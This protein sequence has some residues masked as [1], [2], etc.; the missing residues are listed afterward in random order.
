MS[1][2][3]FVPKGGETLGRTAGGSQ[4][5]ERSRYLT[6]LQ[7]SLAAVKAGGGG[8][9]VLIGGEA[10]V[11]KTTLIRHFC[12]DQQHSARILWGAC[13][14]LFTP[15]ALGPFLAIAETAGGELG[16]L[17]ASEARPHEVV[18]ALFGELAAQKPT[19]LV[20]ED[21]HWAD[22][23]TLDVL[24]LL[25]RRIANAPALVLVT[26]RDDVLGRAH[27][28]RLLLGELPTGDGIER[29]KL[30]PLSPAAVAEL[31]QPHGFNVDELYRLTAGNPF[32][33]TEAL[34]AGRQEIPVTV[35]DAVLARAAR[36]SRGGSVV[37]EAVAVVPGQA[38]LWL[39]EAVGEDIAFLDECVAAGMLVVV[40]GGVT[41]RHEL[42]RLAVEA[43]LAP[44]RRAWLHRAMLTAL[45]APASGA[46]DLARLAHHAEAAH[47]PEAVLR[48]APVAALRAAALGA[49]REA[50]AQYARALRFANAAPPQTLVRLL[51]GRAQE[52]YLT[53]QF[54][55]AIE[56]EERALEVH[57]SAGNLRQVG[58]ALRRL[59]RLRFYVGE[60]PQA[61]QS[62]REAVGL[63]EELPPG[64]ELAW[65]YSTL[66]MFEEDADAI[67]AWG[68]RAIELGQR[69]DEPEILCHALTNVG[70]HELLNGLA[71]GREK[72][73]RSL[74]LAL[75]E[76][77]EEAA[78][79]A[80]S[81][82]AIAAVRT[83]SYDLAERV[84]E[85]GIEYATERD[86]SN[87]RLIQLAQRARLELDRGQWTRA[88]TSAQ[89]ALREDTRPYRVFALPVVGLVRARR[90]ETGVW[91]ALDEASALAPA[92]E[93]LRGAPVAAARAEAAWLEGRPEA[94]VEA[95]QAVF[96]L[97]LQLRAPWGYSELALW[98]WRAGVREMVPDGVPENYAAQIAGHWE[99]AAELWTQLGC[100]YEAALALADADAEEPLLRAR[101]QLHRLG[102][103]PAV[104]IVARRLRE[105]GVRRVPR[106]PR[107]TTRRNPA[108]LTSREVEVLALLSEGL[109][110]A[111]IAE[112]LFLSRK[113]VDHHVSAILRKL[114]VRT[115]S[116]AAAEAIRLAIS[117]KTGSSQDR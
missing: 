107:P 48:Y 85:R 76:G 92:E 23:A 73:E 70:T 16:E 68:T 7:V 91:Q 94:A 108:N 44:A 13:D 38:E 58:D 112:R 43:S 102:A 8:R 89:A 67:Y 36:L 72:L 75:R 5:L 65:A 69:L 12:A 105:R 53:G 60:V 88:V 49:H 117:P 111:E 77:F 10:G 116:E 109:H 27:P 97:A 45:A 95:T 29:L 26:Y 52:C 35:R 9:L 93:L 98:R 79:R 61:K 37:L 39:L 59:S 33:V 83:R 22:Q 62:G 11:G 17:V 2:G 63:L 82:L 42:A 19:I 106:G 1:V 103:H 81:L 90:G 34:A 50:A 74:E 55:A 4:L 96:Q 18:A 47:D 40:P 28:L 25:G 64:R 99:R 115:R 31:A 41:F 3:K 66:S 15:R 32:F 51:E 21:V 80:F 101:D 20:V 86:L 113:T 84:L 100:P 57:R 30:E 24:R 6:A 78:G 114:N 104:D 56:A 46:P 87:Y 110:N 14:A 71:E 54:P